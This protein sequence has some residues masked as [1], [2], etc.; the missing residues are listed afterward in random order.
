M[1]IS[2]AKLVANA[3]PVTKLAIRRSFNCGLP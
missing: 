2:S 1:K 3:K